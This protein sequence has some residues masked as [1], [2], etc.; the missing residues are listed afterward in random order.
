MNKE[1]LKPVVFSLI[2]IAGQLILYMG[3]KSFQ[4]TPNFIGNNIDSN[5]PF[6]NVFIIPYVIWYLFIFYLPILYYKYDK[7]VFTKYVI[8]YLVGIIIGDIIFICYPT[9]INRPEITDGGIINFLVKF[10]YK[11]D[12]PAINCFPSLHCLI[13]FFFMFYT[14][15]LKKLKN[16]YKIIICVVSFLIVCSTVFVKQHVFIDILGGLAVSL[17]VYFIV[18]CN[19]KLVKNIEQK[20]K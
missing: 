2:L 8:S 14:L 4:G 5:I 20:I 12:T 1:K 13:A 18:R 17:L 10:I 6:I 16:I 7:T 3:V 9:I 11:C 15:E 19:K